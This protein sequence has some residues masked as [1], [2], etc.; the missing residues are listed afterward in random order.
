M[1]MFQCENQTKLKHTNINLIKIII[2]IRNVIIDLMRNKLKLMGCR[3]SCRM[4]ADGKQFSEV[5]QET[6]I[7]L[8]KQ[9]LSTY[10]PLLVNIVIRTLICSSLT[11]R[12]T[13]V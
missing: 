1:M 6:N 12:Q 4:D 13:Y 5:V 11:G 7:K 2:R 9:L 3:F 8:I 10:P